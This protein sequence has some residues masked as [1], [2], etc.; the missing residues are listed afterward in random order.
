MIFEFRLPDIGEGLEDAEIVTWLV[1]PGE[2]VERD[3]ALVEVLTDKASSELPSPVAGK[4]INMGGVEG[5]R[6][7]VGEV[8][9]QLEDGSSNTLESVNEEDDQKLLPTIETSEVSPPINQNRVKASPATRKLARELKVDLAKISGS[10]TS[11]RITNE[12][13]KSFSNEKPQDQSLN[14]VAGLEL[15]LEETSHETRTLGFMPSGVHPLRGVRGVIAKNMT[16]SWTQIPHIHT[17]DEFDASLLLDFKERLQKMKNKDTADMTILSI[18]AA[19]TTKV[20]SL[21]PMINGHLIGNPPEKIVI[22]SEINLGIAVASDSGLLVPVI[23][24]AQNLNLFEIAEETSKLIGLARNNKLNAKDLQGATFTITNYGSLGGR[25]ALPI[26][27]KNQAAILGLGKIE[28]RPIVIEGKVEARATLPLVLG[29][30]H[31]LIDGDVVEAFKNSLIDNLLE[32]LN[33]LVR[34]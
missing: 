32:P 14:L 24:N 30:D 9:I 20:L 26:I 11:G 29:A 8:L 25:W 28:E 10:G 16:D 23:K 12:D 27:P 31:R 4:V 7:K 18:V 33:L 3:Q 5:D 19:A 22:P 6:I 1:S 21:F 15:T 17:M 34:N 2:Y 13:V